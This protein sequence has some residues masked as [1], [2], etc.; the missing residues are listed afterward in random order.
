MQEARGALRVSRVSADSS[1]PDDELYEHGCKTL[2]FAVH[3]QFNRQFRNTFLISV[4]KSSRIFFFILILRFITRVLARTNFES[5]WSRRT[6]RRG[7]R[8]LNLATL[9]RMLD[10]STRG[11]T[12]PETDTD[13]VFREFLLLRPAIISKGISRLGAVL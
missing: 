3:R 7:T 13:E 1:D 10:V 2:A 4:E 6:R 5:T 11:D 12:Q 8:A 9:D